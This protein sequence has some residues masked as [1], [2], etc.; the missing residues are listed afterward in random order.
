VDDGFLKCESNRHK[1]WLIFR[2][3][4]F[5]FY[6]LPRPGWSVPYKSIWEKYLKKKITH[7]HL[8]MWCAFRTHHTGWIRIFNHPMLSKS[9]D[10]QAWY[11]VLQ[12]EFCIIYV[13]SLN[14]VMPAYWDEADAVMLKTCKI[15]MIYCWR[16]RDLDYHHHHRWVQSTNGQNVRRHFVAFLAGYENSFRLHCRAIALIALPLLDIFLVANVC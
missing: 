16:D 9:K 11:M 1:I 8:I 6:D 2:Y 10:R 7:T 13:W 4:L 5:F 14:P 15:R 3:F 12:I